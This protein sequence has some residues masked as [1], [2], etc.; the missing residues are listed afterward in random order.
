MLVRLRFMLIQETVFP[1]PSL[2]LFGRRT[3]IFLSA[4]G[5]KVAEQLRA[6][7]YLGKISYGLYIFHV[8]CIDLSVTFARDVLHMRSHLII[9]SD[10]LGV[11]LRIFTCRFERPLLGNALSAIE[12]EIRFCRIAINSIPRV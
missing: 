3:F 2:D 7:V 9:V 4:Y 11:P 6:L 8:L 1:R 5:V 12:G 10:G